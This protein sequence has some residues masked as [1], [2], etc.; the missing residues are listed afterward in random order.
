MKFQE[1]NADEYRV[2]WI[3]MKFRAI[4]SIGISE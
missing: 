2:Y 4:D 1:I 3:I